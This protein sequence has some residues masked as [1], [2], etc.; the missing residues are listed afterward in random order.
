M[1]VHVRRYFVLFAVA[2]LLACGFHSWTSAV[3]TGG[4]RTISALALTSGGGAAGNGALSMSAANAGGMTASGAVLT[5]GNFSVTMGGAPAVITFSAAQDDLAS[6]HCY[7]V[8]YKP[9]AGH[10]RITFTG[11]T[12]AARIRVYT[13]S[14][15]LVRT[16]EK[17]DTGE[18]LDWDVLNSEGAAVDSGVYLYLIDSAGRKKKGK[19]MVIR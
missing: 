3:L 11:L 2:G 12:R 14:G 16:L 13:I 1:T 10:S 17:Y 5:G 15:E 4:F 19:L 18:T 8:P 6:A 7:P 9:S